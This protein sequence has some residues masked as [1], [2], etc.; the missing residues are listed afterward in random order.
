MTWG[1]YSTPDQRFFSLSLSSSYH[2]RGKTAE[3]LLSLIL[4]EITGLIKSGLTMRLHL[5][6][7]YFVCLFFKINSCDLLGSVINSVSVSKVQ[8]CTKMTV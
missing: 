8:H 4:S 6:F 1:K 3:S 5:P 2:K 7:N